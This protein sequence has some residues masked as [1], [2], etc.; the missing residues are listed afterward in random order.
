MIFFETL[1][2]HTLHDYIGSRCIMKFIENHIEYKKKKDAETF[3][4][5][6]IPLYINPDYPLQ[7]ERP[8]ENEANQSKVIEIDMVN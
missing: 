5:V 4:P 3:V 7:E 6:T 2:A 8:K 1:A